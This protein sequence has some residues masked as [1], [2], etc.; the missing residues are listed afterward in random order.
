MRWHV[1]NP[2]G[3]NAP[4]SD[5]LYYQLTFTHQEGKRV[6]QE[7]GWDIYTREQKRVIAR[8]LDFIVHEGGPFAQAA[9]LAWQSYWHKFGQDA[10]TQ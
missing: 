7:L 8:F 9:R 10:V 5:F 1:R 6:F 3:P 4:R 2:P